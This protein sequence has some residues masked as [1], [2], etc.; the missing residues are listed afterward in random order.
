MDDFGGTRSDPGMLGSGI[1]FAESTRY[2]IS[3]I[4]QCSTHVISIIQVFNIHSKAVLYMFKE[5]SAKL[6][7]H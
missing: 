4:M 2:I 1:Y 7:T 3:H 5:M 6:K